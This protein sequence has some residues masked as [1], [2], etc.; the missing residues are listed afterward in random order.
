M[1]TGPTHKKAEAHRARTCHAVD[2]GPRTRLPLACSERDTGDGGR[3][4]PPDGDG[5]AVRGTLREMY[6]R[7][8]IGGYCHLNLGEEATVVGLWPACSPVITCLGLRNNGIVYGASVE[9]RHDVDRR[10][11]FGRQTGCRAVDGLGCGHPCMHLFDVKAR[12]LGGGYAIVGGQIPL[13]TGAALAISYRGGNEVVM[14]QMGDGTTNVGAFHECLNL[15]GVWDLPIV[16]VVVNNLLGMGTTVEASSAEPELWRRGCA[17]RIPGERVD[18]ND[19]LAVR[20]RRGT[21]SSSAGSSSV[22]SCWRRSA[23]GCG[24][25]PWW[26]PPATGPRRTPS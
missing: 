1:A 17:H 2:G 20:R 3:L 19:V 18:G 26:I 16:F 15:A 6:Q 8:K 21:R 24:A 4:L 11:L 9:A 13:A 25:T 23:S 14:C 5:A 22:R 12:L 7:A 10:E